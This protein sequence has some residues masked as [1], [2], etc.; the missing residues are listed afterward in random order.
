MSAISGERYFG[1]CQEISSL[2]SSVAIS[3][4][5]IGLNLGINSSNKIS[6]K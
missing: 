6:S 2:Y 5:T 1:P 4:T 3:P